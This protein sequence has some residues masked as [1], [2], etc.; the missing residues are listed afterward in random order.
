MKKEARDKHFLHKPTY[1]GGSEAMKKFIYS[2][3]RYPDSAITSKTEGIVQ[4]KITIGHKGN[5]LDTQVLHSIGHGCDEEAVRIA[6]MLQFEVPKN[7]GLR[8]R[9]F[10][11]I[12]IQFKLHGM[13]GPHHAGLKVSYQVGSSTATA[14]V[15]Y[16]Y[17]IV[18]SPT[19]T[20]V[21]KP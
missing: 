7:R 13:P 18:P 20:K 3:L 10:K 17:T 14:S 4:V 6:K 9:F 2:N 1:T 8:V 21:S 16:S 12:N 19:K 11:K 5:V 15:S